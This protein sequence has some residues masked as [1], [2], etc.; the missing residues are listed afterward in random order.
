VGNVAPVQYAIRLLI[1]EGSY[2]LQVPGVDAFLEGFDPQ[3]LCYRWV[4][5]DPR[6]DELQRHVL[7][8]VEQSLSR[9]HPR[10]EVFR[11]VCEIT[12]DSVRAEQRVRLL[13][14]DHGPPKER[15]PYLT[16]PWFC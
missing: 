1:P 2:L 10:N 6:V 15:I 7:R 11:Q 16:E 9:R 4:H 8:L 12:A 14:L 5:P 3:A 13:E